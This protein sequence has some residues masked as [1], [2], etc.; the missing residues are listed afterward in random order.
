MNTDSRHL[1]TPAYCNMYQTSDVLIVCIQTL[2]SHETRQVPWTEGHPSLLILRSL[3]P[4]LGSL[5]VNTEYEVRLLS[6][7]TCLW[8]LPAAALSS[9]VGIPL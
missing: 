8:A 3:F 9:R 5:D 1:T 7:K 6:K 2:L 4:A